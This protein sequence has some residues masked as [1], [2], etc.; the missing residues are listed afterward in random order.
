MALKPSLVFRGLATFLNSRILAFSIFD[1]FRKPVLV[2]VRDNGVGTTTISEFFSPR[3]SI[4]PVNLPSIHPRVIYDLGA[5]V[6]VSSLFF[7]SLFPKATIYGFEPLPENFEVCLLNY[8][9]IPNSSQVFPWAVGSKTGQAI[10]DCKNDSRGGR[11]E[12]THQDPN[13]QTI[14][15]IQ[16]KIISIADLIDKEGL[17]PPEFLKID[18]EGADFI[19]FYREEGFTTYQSDA[20]FLRRVNFFDLGI[21]FESGNAPVGETAGDGQ[22]CGEVGGEGSRFEHWAGALVNDQPA[23]QR[24]GGNA[25]EYGPVAQERLRFLGGFSQGRT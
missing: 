10:F 14:A 9:G 19:F 18:V 21:S 1:A 23:D 7:A 4:M 17:P 11:L 12:S 8:R 2:Y 13:L 6:G 22:R 5:N 15:Q 16:V 24:R 20:A 25:G 3:S